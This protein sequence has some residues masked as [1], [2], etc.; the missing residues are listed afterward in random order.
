MPEQHGH[1]VLQDFLRMLPY[2]DYTHPEGRL[3]LA[4]SLLEAD[5]RP[6]LGPKS[7]VAY[8]R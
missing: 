3:N 4:S 8:G 2:G 5:L 6:D 1:W 7:Y